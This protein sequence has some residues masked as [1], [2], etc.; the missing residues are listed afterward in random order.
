MVKNIDRL[1]PKAQD[2]ALKYLVFVANPKIFS[3]LSFFFTFLFLKG[4][5][6]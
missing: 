3:L 1:L 6:N 5:T 2:D 4:Y